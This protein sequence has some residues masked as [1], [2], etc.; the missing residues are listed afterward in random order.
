VLA[1]FMLAKGTQILWVLNRSPHDHPR[2]HKSY[3]RATLGLVTAGIG[4]AISLFSQ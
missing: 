3:G 4:L 2:W 1:S